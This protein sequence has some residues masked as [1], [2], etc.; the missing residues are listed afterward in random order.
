MLSVP[1]G[2]EPGNQS[3]VTSEKSELKFQLERPAPTEN[4]QLA[5]AT[6]SLSVDRE[7]PRVGVQSSVG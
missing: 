3:S 7:S 4:W 1:S 2:R 5:L 6:I